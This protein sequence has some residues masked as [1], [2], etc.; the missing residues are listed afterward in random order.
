[1]ETQNH[2]GSLLGGVLLVAGC[3]IGAGMLGL[4]VLSALGGFEPSVFMFILSWLFM[5]SAGL[6]LLEVNLWFKEDV[7]IISMAGRSLGLPGKIV[8]WS[9]FL[10]LFYA[11][12]VAYI[13]GIGQLISDFFLEWTNIVIIPGVGSFIACVLLSFM[14]YLGTKAVDWVNR[15][16]MIGLIASYVLI[17]YFGSSRVNPE[18]LQHHDW[19]AIFLV[20]PAMIISFGF[21]NLIPTLTTYLNRDVAKLRLT[22]ILGSFI[23]L[24]IYL[25]WE[26][27]ILGLVPVEGEGGFRE[28]Y[29]QGDMVTRTLKSALGASWILD[30]ANA[31]AFFAIVTSFLGVSLSF[32]DFLADGFHIKKTPRGKAFLCTLVIALPFAF[33]LIYPKIFLTALNYAGSFGAVILFGILPAAMAWGGRYIKKIEAPRLLPGGKAGLVLLTLGALAIIALQIYQ[34]YFVEVHS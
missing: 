1:M 21:H 11:L 30:L 16:L 33:A 10:F 3:C 12:M 5:L 18:Y 32:V 15:L 14:I 7:S 13:S 8:A 6:L 31:F 28:A 22:I 34:D 2:S 26:Y 29:N 27:L 19:S 4:P 9:G 25:L 20:V 24:V 17:I 23:P